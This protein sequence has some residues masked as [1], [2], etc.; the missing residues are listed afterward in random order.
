[1]TNTNA[2]SGDRPSTTIMHR[3]FGGI[4]GYRRL[5]DRASGICVH[6]FPIAAISQLSAAGMLATA[7]AYVMTDFRTAYIG[8]SSRVS[9]RVGEHAS[10]PAKTAFA[11][12]VFVVA[13]REGCA[14]DR[15]L[16]QD[17]QYRLTNLAFG[18][19]VVTVSKGANPVEPELSD[20]DRSTADRI[21]DDALRL[22]YDA[23]CRIFQPDAGPRM[24]EPLPADDV[25]DP[26]DSGPMQIGVTTV[27]IGTEEFELRYDDAWARGY[28]AGGHFVVAAGSEVRCQTNDSVNA[29]TRTRREELFAAGVLAE[30][31]GVDGRRRLIVAVAFSSMSIAAKAICGAHTAGRW[32]RLTPSRVVVLAGI[33]QAS[34]QE[35]AARTAAS[36]T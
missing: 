13:G 12:E 35:P 24:R 23:G 14:I 27:P 10:D 36:G 5:S 16:A 19:G 31:P 28:W 7:G 29:I 15:T 33:K 34:W 32:G 21:L 26:A 20:S 22:L 8:E 6:A 17:M 30:I 25:A 1:M 9:R 2:A 18:A 3:P 11:R 4:A